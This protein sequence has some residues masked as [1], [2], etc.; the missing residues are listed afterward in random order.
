VRRSRAPVG[1]VAFAVSIGVEK[2]WR[3]EALIQ[4]HG[5]FVEVDLAHGQLVI[6]AIGEGI[7]QIADPVIIQVGLPRVRKPETIIDSIGDAIAILVRRVGIDQVHG[8]LRPESQFPRPPSGEIRRSLPQHFARFGIAARR[9][10]VVFITDIPGAKPL[11]QRLTRLRSAHQ[12]SPMNFENRQVPDAHHI[13]RRV[14]QLGLGVLAG[15][16]SHPRNG[17]PS[18]RP[19]RRQQRRS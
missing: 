6:G 11:D 14:D 12:T 17:W 3:C 13:V 1:F 19:I 18:A 5:G 16:G 10:S 2:R 4:R 9:V 8:R 7:A 15:L